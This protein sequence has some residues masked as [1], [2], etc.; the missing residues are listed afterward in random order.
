MATIRRLVACLA[1]LS[2][3]CE[4]SDATAEYRMLSAAVQVRIGDGIG[5][6][7]VERI[8]Q[9]ALAAGVDAVVFTEPDVRRVDY[10]PPF[11]RSLLSGSHEEH[12]LD[13]SD[14]MEPYL[15]AVA[16]AQERFPQLVLVDGVESRPFYYWESSGDG[17]WA[18]NQW[19]KRLA[20]VGLNN[21]E[22][23][24]AL[25][26][27]GGSGIWAWSLSSWLLLWPLL[28]LAYALVASAHPLALRLSVG[29]AS[30]L[31]L[32]E[33]APFGVPLWDAYKGDMG[34]APY[35]HY[36]DRVNE[37]GGVALWLPVD[38]SISGRTIA[39]FAGML[40]ALVSPAEVGDELVKTRGAAAFAALHPGR[41]RA[42]DPGR[43]WDKSL[44]EYLNGERRHPMWAL[45]CVD[46]DSGADLSAV[47][48]VLGV[49][50]AT[51][52]GLFEAMRMG[53]MYAVSGGDQRL[54]LELFRA[55]GEDA[56]AESGETL[57][58]ARRIRLAARLISANGSS[59]QVRLQLIRA[60]TI[61]K[62]VRGTTPL[63]MRYVW[64]VE[65]EESGKTYFRLMAQ[66]ADS[67]LVSNPIFAQWEEP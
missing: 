24:S 12:S 43:A 51:R 36:I 22:A 44:V 32:V 62:E 19:N 48:T 3:L 1:L 4:A 45:G 35:Q 50:Q 20:A 21:G 64:Q 13:A 47:L 7:G 40:T 59:Q 11:L 28:G 46:Y 14:S 53:R 18:L 55:A 30:L 54:Q 8:A 66:S 17:P 58:G 42:A 52:A 15:Q 9:E 31:F 37:G 39:L 33:N 23:Y 38:E 57:V 6:A 10:G 67:R 26:V 63:D 5:T 16:H 65:G 25:P 27:S 56:S 41:E 60:G 49:R 34:P 29:A 2:A 61:V